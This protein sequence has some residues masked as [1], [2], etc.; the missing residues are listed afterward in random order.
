MDPSP[1][2]VPINIKPLLQDIE[3][4]PPKAAN[5][6]AGAIALA[7]SNIFT[8]QLSPVQTAVLL[9]RLATTGLDHRPDVLAKC[10]DVMRSAA[11]TVDVEEL[12]RISQSKNLRHGGYEG[13][14]VW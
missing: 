3:P 7:I 12:R 1:E 2:K 5:A 4:S 6:N 9:D 13:G 11:E 14:L 10:S 8:N